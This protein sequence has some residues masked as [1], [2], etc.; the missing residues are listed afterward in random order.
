MIPHIHHAQLAIWPRCWFCIA[1]VLTVLISGAP[2]AQE[3]STTAPHTGWF[4][5]ANVGLGS[6]QANLAIAGGYNWRL[7]FNKRLKFGLGLRSTAWTGSN[8]YYQTA[9]AKYTSNQEGPQVL[10]VETFPGNIDSVQTSSTTL[11][12]QNLFLNA[13]FAISSKWDVG[14]NIDLVG[15]SLG[16]SH[17]G[18][19]VSSYNTPGT[20]QFQNTATTVRPTGLNLLLVSDNDIGSLNS[21]AYVRYHLTDKIGLQAGMSFYFAELTSSDKLKAN[22]D[23]DR[24]RHKGLLGMVGITWYPA[25]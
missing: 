5:S 9:P 22:F 16:G 8:Q 25:R 21:E 14:A 10:F 15:F 13:E 11:F 3:V 18:Q 6:G 2:R 24:W 4:T 19:F 17:G 1:L 20:P 23:N 7:L 12:S